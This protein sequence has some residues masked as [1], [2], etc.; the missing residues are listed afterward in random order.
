[1]AT[2]RIAI[3]AGGFSSEFPVS[4]KSAQGIK[5]FLEQTSYETYIVKITRDLW[6]V[7]LPDGST[8]EIDKMTSLL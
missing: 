3:V 8:S 2:R 5:T 4:M 6:E 7:Q 1:M